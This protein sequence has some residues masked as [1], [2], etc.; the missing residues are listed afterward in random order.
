MINTSIGLM[1]GMVGT[2]VS[3]SPTTPIWV[4]IVIAVVPPVIGI[5]WDVFR[6]V[7]EKKGWFSKKTG[8]ELQEYFCFDADR[9][10]LIESGQV[11]A[12]LL[13]VYPDREAINYILFEVIPSE[14][15]IANANII[16]EDDFEGFLEWLQGQGHGREGRRPGGKYPG[17]RLTCQAKQEIK[18]Q[19]GF[20]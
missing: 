20:V 8:E 10:D 9:T 3:T 19:E 17:F 2:A 14:E 1:S 18:F 15:D 11:Q 13:E 4:S 5:I 7:A 12:A 16:Y 6:H